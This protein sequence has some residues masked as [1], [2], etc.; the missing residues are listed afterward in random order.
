MPR[1]Y[2]DAAPELAAKLR[3]RRDQLPEAA[4]SYYSVLFAVADVHGSDADDQATITRVGDGGVEIELR[5]G[6]GDPYFRRR[7]DGRDTREIRVY[8]HGGNDHAVVRGAAR[9]SIPVRVVG[10]NGT[11]TFADSSLVAGRS[12]PTRFHDAGTVSGVSYGPDTAFN[13]RPWVRLFG[14]A[15]PPGKDYGTRIVPTASVST[16]RGLGI[17]PE[18]GFKRYRYGFG[19]VPYATMLQVEL[20][21]STALQGFELEF[22]GDKRFESARHHLR[23]DVLLSE[24]EVGEFRGLGNQNSG[25]QSDFFRVH[26]KQYTAYPA[27]AYAFGAESDISLGPTVRYVV[28]DSTPDRFISETRPYG[29]GRF[30][31]AGLQLKVEHDNRDDTGFPR[32]GGTVELTAS[33][34]PALWSVE[35]PYQEI[36][37]VATHHAPLPGGSVLAFRLGGK[38]LF[39]NFPY[40]DAAFLGGSSSLRTVDRQRYAGDA[41]VYGSGEVRVPLGKFGFLLPWDAGLIGFADVGRVYVDGRS[42]GGWHSGVGGGFWLGVLSP[43][44]S[45]TVLLT[46]SPDRRLLLGLGVDY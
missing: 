2:H 31:Q 35:T 43:K 7:F 40:F 11:N 25:E 41:S 45:V 42:A 9:H 30:G 5:S 12:R 8:L 14:E 19:Y 23:A 32:R 33:A 46:N 26:Q 3:A 10:G 1:E 4:R 36:T 38:K 37:A 17:A 39:G 21:Y 22:E 28:T 44:T 18:V 16:G 34:Y 29:F 6:G 20:G 24:I 15:A 13:R 27:L